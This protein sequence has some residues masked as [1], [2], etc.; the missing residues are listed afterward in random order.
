MSATCCSAI[1]LLQPVT[2]KQHESALTFRHNNSPYTL[3]FGTGSVIMGTT[4][5]ASGIALFWA[6]GPE[7]R[8]LMFVFFLAPRISSSS[9]RCGPQ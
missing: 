9:V 5:L 7:R 2:A 1:A 3:C 6:L 4:S 8:I